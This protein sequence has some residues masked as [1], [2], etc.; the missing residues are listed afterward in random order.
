MESRRSLTFMTALTVVLLAA[1]VLAIGA[2][3]AYLK[4]APERDAE[5]LRQM[6]QMDRVAAEAGRQA[7][8]RM[9]EVER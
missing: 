4:A 9:A 6:E 5:L 1:L 8:Q 3:R 2:T 7:R